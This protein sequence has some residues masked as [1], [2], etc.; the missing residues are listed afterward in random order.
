MLHI[1]QVTENFDTTLNYM[2]F[3]ALGNVNCI[4]CGQCILHWTAE[5][6]KSVPIFTSCPPATVALSGGG[7]S[8]VMLCHLYRSVALDS[9]AADLF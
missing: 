3:K 9:K 6:E 2:V 1:K 4:N 7:S 5:L 8:S